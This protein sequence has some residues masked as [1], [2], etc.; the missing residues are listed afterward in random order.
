M[1]PGRMMAVSMEDLLGIVDDRRHVGETRTMRENLA[2]RDR[3]LAAAAELGP[4]L[5]HAIVVFEQTAI[6]QLVDHR[7]HDALRRRERHRHG[8][9][10]P[11]SAVPV[12]AERR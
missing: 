1:G 7:R 3:L 6:G 8:V 5:R 10:G 4:V 11:G 2:N 9:L 12:G